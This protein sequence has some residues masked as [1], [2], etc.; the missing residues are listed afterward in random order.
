MEH[1]PNASGILKQAT[2]QQIVTVKQPR[3]STS[4]R[5]QQNGENVKSEKKD[6]VVGQLL[7]PTLTLGKAKETEEAFLPGPPNLFEATNL[8][9]RNFARVG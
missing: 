8:A 4:K 2:G 3:E 5:G 9:F 6:Q 7:G 1:K